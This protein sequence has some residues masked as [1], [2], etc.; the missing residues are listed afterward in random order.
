MKRT[1]QDVKQMRAMFKQLN[2]FMLFMWRLGLGPIIS[3]PQ[4]GYIMVL[5]STGHKS[6]LLR[7]APVNFARD[8]DTV[9]CLAGLGA[10]T[11]WYRNLMADPHCEV[12]LPDGRWAGIAEEI[13]DETERLPILRRVLIRSGFAAKLFDGIE[14]AYMSEDHLRA[15]DP[16]YK[17]IKIKLR[18]QTTGAGGPGDLVWVWPVM[19]LI[20]W[21]L[22]K[23]CRVRAKRTK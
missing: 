18:E 22:W 11:H 8:G 23:L 7:R 21:L 5:V 6:G 15:L 14:P 19:G 9:Y 1:E 16:S 2:K 4:S 17:V 10:K 20:A 12:W 13:K 3:T